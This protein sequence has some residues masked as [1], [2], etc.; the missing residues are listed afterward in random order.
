MNG[1]MNGVYI[2]IVANNTLDDKAKIEIQLP[3]VMGD[4]VVHAR[5][6]TLLAGDQYGCFFL[7]EINDLVLV[8]FEKGCGDD[9]VIIGSIL[10][11]KDQAPD[12]NSN[13]ENNLKVIKTRG[14][15][16]IRFVDEKGKEKIE[17]TNDESKIIIE[18]AGKKITID[19]PDGEILITGKTVT[20]SATETINI[21]ADGNT[22]IKGKLVDI[23]P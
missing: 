2:G 20:I 21:K 22:T 17:I 12:A 8:A 18:R 14:G 9:P 10:S 1:L 13:G 19:S 15:N 4:V 5:I 16:E 11:T 23:N 6:A 3:D 7:P